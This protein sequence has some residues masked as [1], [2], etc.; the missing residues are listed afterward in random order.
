MA[1]LE[2]IMILQSNKELFVEVNQIL[3]PLL[4]QCTTCHSL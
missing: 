1:H 3:P 2:E 4:G